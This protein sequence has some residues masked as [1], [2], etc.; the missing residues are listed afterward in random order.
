MVTIEKPESVMI[1]VRN[2]KTNESKS[3]TVYGA[4]VKEVHEKIKKTFSR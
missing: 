3:I 4:S 1:T 2:R